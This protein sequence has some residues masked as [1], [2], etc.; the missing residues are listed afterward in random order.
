MEPEELRKV[1]SAVRPNGEDDLDPGLSEA[2]RRLQEDPELCHWFQWQ[3]SLDRA[4]AEKLSELLPPP[5]L[6]AELLS[7]LD[8]QPAVLWWQRPWAWA[9]GLC[10][11]FGVC[12][13]LLTLPTN[14]GLPAS[15]R[16]EEAMIQQIESA[17]A[18]ENV[19]QKSEEALRWLAEKR[20]GGVFAR[21]P[22]G[23]E[24]ASQFSCTTL[25]WEGHPVALVCFSWKGRTAHLFVIEE[26]AVEPG[27]AESQPLFRRIG[28]W[29]TALW[30]E[31]DRVYLL[32]GLQ[33]Q[34]SLREFFGG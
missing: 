27:A 12:A 10:V 11:F 32:M 14:R 13:W 19:F 18:F 6:K 26:G 9:T 3:R 33:E 4:I 8:R 16:F 7:L 24:Q 25:W 2:F 1:L 21:L 5:S 23:L 15:L 29:E 22:A 30:K 17:P 28:A 31:G 20:G 34:G